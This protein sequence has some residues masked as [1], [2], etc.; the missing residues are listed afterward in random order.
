MEQD[1]GFRVSRSKARIDV[2]EWMW[3][4]YEEYTKKDKRHIKR[5]IEC[6]GDFLTDPSGKYLVDAHCSRAER[7]AYREKRQKRVEGL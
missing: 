3:N 5:A 4:Y 7:I 1:E 2:L 6:F